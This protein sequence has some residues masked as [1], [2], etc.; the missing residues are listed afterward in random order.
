MRQA[1]TNMLTM[2]DGINKRIAG[3]WPGRG[4]AWYRA[5]WIECGE[6]MEHHGY[7]WWRRQRPDPAQVRLEIVDIWH[8]GM[9]AIL[10]EEGGVRASAARLESELA[11]GGTAGLSVPEA[12]EALALHALAERSFCAARF[13]D[14][15]AAAGLTFGQLCSA[16]IGKNVLN[17]FR[18]EH[19]Y[20]EGAYRKR[21]RGREDNEH[22]AELA[23]QLDPHSASYAEDLYRALERRYWECAA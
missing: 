10:A 19:G 4:F 1:L 18:Q 6:L 17:F 23:G 12:T 5:V 14:L 15:M 9:S 13:R 11:A 7:K 21:W 20:Q 22:L 8:F 16:Y 3:D 2:Q